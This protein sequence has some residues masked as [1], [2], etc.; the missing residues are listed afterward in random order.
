MGSFS[1][2]VSG[3][4]VAQDQLESVSN[5]LANIDT[6]GYKDQN[7]TFADIY[8]QTGVTNGSGDPL[9][10][11]SGVKVQQTVSNFTEGTVNPTGIPSNMA[12]NGNG[13][14]ITQGSNGA[15]N[16]T[17]AGD[18]TVNKQ[19]Q[20][21]APDGNMVQGYPA[22]GGVVNTTAG[23]QP[24]LV[25][26]GVTSPAVPSTTIGVTANLDAGAAV[27]SADASTSSPLPIFDSLGTQQNLAVTFTKTAANTWG[28]SISLPGANLN[29]AQAGNVTVAS[30]TMN[31]NSSGVLV[32]TEPTG[33]S[34]TVPPSSG[35][36]FA[37]PP[38]G[39]GAFADGA[40]NATINWSLVSQGTP[41]VTQTT[42]TSGISANQYQW[43][44]QRHAYRLFDWH[45]R[46][47]SG[48]VHQRTDLDRW[49][50]GARQLC[51]H[52]GPGRRG[53]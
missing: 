14:F 11:G 37:V 24:L 36:S 26:A 34:A 9:Q 4:Q 33:G 15:Y 3:L 52:A 22:S 35:I 40:A 10:T 21:E 16:Y 19:G 38:S 39:G 20:I 53:Q 27:G 32:S 2:P 46:H 25:G 13:F 41:T 7:L 30:G 45:R 31:F 5:N 50:G 44:R 43:F 29:P 48:H 23:L 6:D 51:Q 17:R 8:S 47:R 28:Y 12:I 1:I 49:P 42:A 18:F